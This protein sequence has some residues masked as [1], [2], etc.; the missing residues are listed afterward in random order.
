MGIGAAGIENADSRQLGVIPMLRLPFENIGLA[1]YLKIDPG[2]LRTS[3]AA[4][5]SGKI[6]V[7]SSRERH[8][9]LRTRT[10]P[11]FPDPL[12]P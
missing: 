5:A 1:G 3:S 7:L 11:D 6:D 4:F 10:K 8:A 12:S 9:L 2:R